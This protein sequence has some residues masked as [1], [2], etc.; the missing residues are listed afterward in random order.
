MLGLWEQNRIPDAVDRVAA[1]AGAPV[2]QLLT[3]P[4]PRVGVQRTL[5]DHA[6][7]PVFSVLIYVDGEGRPEP[8]GRVEPGA[9][10]ADLA[11]LPPRFCQHR[12]QERGHRLLVGRRVH[13]YSRC[14][15]RFHSK[16]IAL[17]GNAE[18]GVLRH[19][20]GAAGLVSR[21]GGEAIAHFH[22]EVGIWMRSA[23]TY[24]D[25]PRMRGSSW[26]ALL[27]F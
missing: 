7:V 19:T 21:N 5:R 15:L 9:A 20:P 11:N 13:G 4:G 22:V 1:L 17:L 12:V 2:H 27:S 25:C 3:E 26:S 10:R 23:R 16:R 14:T 8:V 18:R 6:Q 24:R